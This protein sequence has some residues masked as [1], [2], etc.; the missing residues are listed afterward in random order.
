M[1]ERQERFRWLYREHHGEV[2]RY[3]AR[4]LARAADVDDV[5]AEVFTV[6]WR[7]INDVPVAPEA[8]P[9]LYGVARRVLANEFRRLERRATVVDDA[10][11][12]EAVE[13]DHADD[14]LDRLVA[15]AA[16]ATLGA[17]DREVLRLVAWENLSSTQVAVVLGCLRTTAA[18][19]VRRARRRLLAA[20][21]VVDRPH[22]GSQRVGTKGAR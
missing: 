17:D 16:F 2:H 13:S 5:V 19:R 7:R 21:A 12:D 22:D 1:T 4:R 9:W 11:L 20:M 8:L 14:V 6:M 3:V 15:I 18:M 10:A